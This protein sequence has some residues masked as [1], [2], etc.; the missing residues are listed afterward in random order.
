MSVPTSIHEPAG[1][2]DAVSALE[3]G[4]REALLR[5]FGT[6]Y[7]ELDAEIA[8]ANPLCRT[9]GDCCQFAKYGH[10]LYATRAEALYFASRRGWPAEAFEK[11]ACPY[12]RDNRCTARHA[13]PLG[14]RV[15]FCDPAWKGRGEELTERYL[16]RIGILSERLGIDREYRPFLEHLESFRSGQDPAGDLGRSLG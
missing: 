16:K 15:F 10:R 14:C 1:Q 3:A 11:D 5:E 8:A 6:L 2:A 7:A 9:S 12:L 13:R 4:T